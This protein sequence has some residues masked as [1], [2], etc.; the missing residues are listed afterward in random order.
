MTSVTDYIFQDD[1]DLSNTQG[2]SNPVATGPLPYPV[3]TYRSRL[4]QS[5]VY[6]EYNQYSEY[7]QYNEY[8]QYDDYNEH[9]VY[10]EYIK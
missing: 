6:I 5:N 7:N 9:N 3:P 1:D 8:N 2:I 4:N 10:A